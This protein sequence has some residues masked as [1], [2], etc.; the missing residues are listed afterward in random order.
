MPP[1]I[2]RRVAQRHRA[3][4]ALRD[5]RSSNIRMEGMRIS[6]AELT[7]LLE[8]VVG[9]LS[10]MV[11][12][13]SPV[14]TIGW[15]AV[16]PDGSTVSGTLALRAS[17]GDEEVRSWAEVVLDPPGTSVTI[18]PADLRLVG[19]APTTSAAA[20]VAL[21]YMRDSGGLVRV[22]DEGEDEQVGDEGE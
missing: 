20:R 9:P 10:K 2:A 12:H 19:P 17:V 7:K 3:T 21:R 16:D 22:D 8:P 13:R 11:F 5:S 18:D 1:E 14:G 15:A 6:A 4:A